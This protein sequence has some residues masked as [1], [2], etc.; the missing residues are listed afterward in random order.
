MKKF[1]C[2][3]LSLAMI[4]S[5]IPMTVF[6]SDII[7]SV[8]VLGIDE[9][10]DGA[11]YD[12]F[13]SLPSNATYTIFKEPEWY[14]ETDERFLEAGDTFKAGHSYTV[15]VWLE[16]GKG[17]EFAST[18]TTTDVKASINGKTAKAGKAFEY[19]RWAMVVASYT[20]PEVAQAKPVGKVSIEIARPK[21]GEKVSYNAK[22]TGE[23]V[24]LMERIPDLMDVYKNAIN[25][26]E[27][28]DNTTNH[29]MLEGETFTVGHEYGLSVFVE[30]EDGYKLDES[31][32]NYEVTINGRNP[33]VMSGFGEERRGYYVSYDCI[34]EVGEVNFNI[35]EPKVGTAPIFKG[36]VENGNV[37]WEVTELSYFDESTREHLKASDTFE[38]GHYYK[39]YF[40]MQAKDGYDFT[41]DANGEFDKSKITINGHIPSNTGYFSE[42][43][44]TGYVESYYGPLKKNSENLPLTLRDDEIVND[45][46]QSIYLYDLEKPKADANPDYITVCLSDYY[47]PV[48][49]STEVENWGVCWKN[50]TTGEDLEVENAVFE[51]GNEYEAHIRVTTN[52]KMK[53]DGIK[54]YVD[55]A[56]PDRI[57][58][59]KDDEVTLVYNFGVLGGK[60]ETPKEPEKEPETENPTETEKPTQTEKTE[61]TDKPAEKPTQTEKPQETPKTSFVDVKKGQYYYDAVMWAAEKGIT[62]G[63][64]ANT[65]SPDANCSRA[66]VVTFLHRMI[67]SPE[68]AAITLPFADVKTSDYFYKPVKWAFGSKITGGTSNTTFSPD[69]SCTRAQVVTFLWRTA[70]QQKASVNSN[71]FTDVKADSYYY[72][73]VLWAVENGITGGT[74]ATTF[75]PDSDCTRAQVVTFLYRFIND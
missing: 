26:I 6:A 52:F 25:G 70:G 12:R 10:V 32:E 42:V 62:G 75:S 4:L 74:S 31:Y 39:I 49:S 27:W 50:V 37:N 67:A 15:S 19:Q 30:P 59:V 3:L 7:Q 68:P 47:Y 71:P 48:N 17:S 56:E 38:E 73:A 63:T 9:P 43:W 55:G 41:K 69:E 65:F 58:N 45:I 20:F 66:Q 57:I 24:K 40:R 28:D 44:R 34:G 64:S 16:A 13:A 22:I 8:V 35:V 23:G 21:P 1:L 53:L 18:A 36:Y 2:A 61:E 11:P 54:A 14:D 5:L 33:T 29:N 72:D 60:Q 51:E 46:V